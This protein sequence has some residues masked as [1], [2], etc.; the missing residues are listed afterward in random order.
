MMR[1]M[2]EMIYLKKKITATKNITFISTYKPRKH[3]TFTVCFLCEQLL[4]ETFGGLLKK[5]LK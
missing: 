5:R 2:V 3:V 4:N 1:G